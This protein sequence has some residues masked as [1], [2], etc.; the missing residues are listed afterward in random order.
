MVEQWQNE[1]DN[2]VYKREVRPK[3][4]PAVK[5]REAKK[6]VDVKNEEVKIEEQ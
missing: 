1:A 3:E 6:N 2:P 5:N 4:E